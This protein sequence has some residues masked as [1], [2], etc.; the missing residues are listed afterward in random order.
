MSKSREYVARVAFKYPDEDNSQKWQQHLVEQQVQQ[1]EARHDSQL[2]PAMITAEKLNFSY[3]VTG[4]SEQLRPVRV[5]DD[6]AKTYIQMRPE[7]QNREAP[8]ACGSGCRWKRGDD[9]LS[10]S[11]A[12]LHRGSSV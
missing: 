12:D 11:R 3:K 8:G 6:G 10:R 9:K 7:M 1:R 5:Y 4:R 2:T